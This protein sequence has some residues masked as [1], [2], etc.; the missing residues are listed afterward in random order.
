MIAIFVAD[1]FQCS[2][3]AYVYDTSIPGGKCFNQGAFFVAT[4]ALTIFTDLLVLFLPTWIIFGLQMP[5]RRKIAVIFILSLGLG[6]VALL[7][8]INT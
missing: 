8:P 3:L 5:M 6:Y 2:P 7:L 4:A 1:I